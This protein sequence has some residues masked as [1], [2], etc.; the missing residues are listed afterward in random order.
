MGKRKGKRGEMPLLLLLSRHQRTME[1]REFKKR[2]E[3]RERF[4]MEKKEN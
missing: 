2:M 3:R 4:F 1:K